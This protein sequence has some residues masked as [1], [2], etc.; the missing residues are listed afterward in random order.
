MEELTEHNLKKT[1]LQLE[2][3][4]KTTELTQEVNRILSLGYNFY[5]TEEAIGGILSAFHLYLGT[6]VNNIKLHV[7]NPILVGQVGREP[8]LNIVSGNNLTK[9]L[10]K[11]LNI[12][13]GDG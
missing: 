12:K 4:A 11:H 13:E 7:K 1:L 8:Y 10:L 2:L 6:D 9:L 5:T 3:D